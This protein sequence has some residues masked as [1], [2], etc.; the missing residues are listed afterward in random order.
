MLCVLFHSGVMCVCVCYTMPI[1]VRCRLAVWEDG[2]DVI[3]P[4]VVCYGTR[5]IKRRFN[6]SIDVVI[7][8]KKNPDVNSSVSHFGT[9]A[10]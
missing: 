10:Y 9:S 8:E 3:K 1:W 2:D 5:P 7:G 6:E 4:T